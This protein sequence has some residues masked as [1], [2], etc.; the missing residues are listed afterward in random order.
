MS[1]YA[2]GDIQGCYSPL[3]KLLGK[4]QFDPGKD[5]LWFTGD[6]VNRGPDSL[7]TL[8]FIKNLG[9]SQRTVL[10]NHD[11]H[12]L[13]L[14]SKAH[15]GWEEDTV[16]DILQADDRDELIHWLKHLP[17]LHYDAVLGYAMSH[18]G[19]APSWD[20]DTAKALAREVEH[21][22]QSDKTHEFLHHMYGNRPDQWSNDLEGWDR[23]RCITNYFTRMRF[24]Y[25]D[26]RLELRSKG[27]IDSHP[28]DLIPWFSVPGRLNADLNIVFG[29]WAALGGVTN[30]PRVFALDTGCI[31]G[32]CLTAMRLEDGERI[33][34]SCG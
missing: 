33:S 5:K 22:L 30:T 32:F 28:A 8:R 25:L 29:H 20:L 15:P 13:A 16:A 24:C 34:V 4:I 27:T 18:A 11:L 19:L 6:L 23:L 26:G 14:A 31:W 9:D 21:V 1:T 3:Q 2:I 17:L 7:Q 12:L 10:G